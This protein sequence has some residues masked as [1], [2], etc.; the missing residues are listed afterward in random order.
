MFEQVKNRAA[1]S[2]LIDLLK[3]I[4]AGTQS[5]SGFAY[6][7]KAEGEKL[8]KAE[9]TFVHL[10]TSVSNSD[11]QIKAVATQAAID[12]LNGQSSG[13]TQPASSQEGSGAAV[14]S[15][16]YDFVNLDTIPDINRGGRK[17]DSYPFD[18]LVAHPAQPH[19]FF[20]PASEAR[21]NPAKTLASTVASATKRY[22]GERVF[23]VRKSADASGKV[24]G[25]YVIRTK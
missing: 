8:T 9:P 15:M 22:K 23:T 6:V 14:E 5:A 18:S 4:V 20:V 12:A 19:A 21:P 10:D 3:H 13:A 25:A 2:T 16:K 17:S 7:P 24:T 1:K 11:G